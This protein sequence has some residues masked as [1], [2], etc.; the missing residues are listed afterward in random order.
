MTTTLVVGKF[1]PPHAGHS[2]VI[3]AAS[4]PGGAR[5]HVV[6]CAAPT[7]PIPAEQRAAWI[8]R[9]HPGTEVTVVADICGHLSDEC[10]PECSTAWAGLM[11]EVLGE[12]IDE[13]YSSEAY[14]TPFASALGARHHAVDPERRRHPVSGTAVRLD[15]YAHW[16]HLSPWVRAHYVVRVA[17]VGAESTGTTTL[18]REL[19]RHYGT[20]WVPEFG[21]A[22]S[23]AKLA[24][25]TNDR[26]T[27]ADFET[28]AHTQSANEDAL[29][30]S[31][32]QAPL[33]PG[34]RPLLICDTDALATTIWE[35]RYLAERHLR[36]KPSRMHAPMPSTS[37]PTGTSPSS[38]TA[39]AT[40]STCAAR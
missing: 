13:V 26:W 23:E 31:V 18:A 22:Y 11:T 2:S 15:P 20:H 6:V 3:A 24:E 9:G 32:A 10:E 40:G 19:A 38:T 39:P 14:G 37:S 17:V 12:R 30:E 35:R 36:C 27:P 1:L 34:R 33:T 4:A 28:I 25:G 16:E 21:R 5:C 8:R 7:D 29:A